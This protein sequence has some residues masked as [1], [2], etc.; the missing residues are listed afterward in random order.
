MWKNGDKDIFCLLS[1]C[2]KA[3]V[4]FPQFHIWVWKT[5][6]KPRMCRKYAVKTVLVFTQSVGNVVENCGDNV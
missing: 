3:R 1:G 2:V 4:S 6:C 5:V